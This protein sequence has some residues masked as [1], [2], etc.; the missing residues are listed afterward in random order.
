MYNLL[1]EN[2]TYETLT[3]TTCINPTIKNTSCTGGTIT[4]FYVPATEE[5]SLSSSYVITLKE[6]RSCDGFE[7]VS[8]DQAGEIIDTL[9][10]LSAICYRSIN[11]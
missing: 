10:Q 8:E 7:N 5:G 1:K 9:Y 6:L 11:E 4:E 3:G 2:Y